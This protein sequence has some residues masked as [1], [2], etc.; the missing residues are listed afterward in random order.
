MLFLRVLLRRKSKDWI[1]W[2]HPEKCVVIQ[3]S[4]KRSTISANYTLHNHQLDVVDSSKY[5]GVTINKNLRWDD[6]I[7]NI[8]ARANRTLGFLKRNLKGCKTSARA[9]AYETIVP[10]TLEYAASIWDPYNTGQI[11]QLEKVQRRATRFTTKNYTERQPGS[12]T[13]MVTQLGWEPLQVRRVKIRL[14][15]LFK[16]QYNLVAIPA[17][18]Y[19]LPSDS[20]TRAEYLPDSVNQEGC[21]P[22]LLFPKINPGMEQPSI[23]S[24]NSQFRGGVQGHIGQLT[25]CPVPGRVGKISACF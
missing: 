6:H 13:Q 12:V 25:T 3:I 1:V 22:K 16:I 9:R 4:S 24:N 15:L 14:L 11:N 10:P 19:L 7:N 5:L 21:L 17:E 8:T 20:R 18:A 2:N 23:G